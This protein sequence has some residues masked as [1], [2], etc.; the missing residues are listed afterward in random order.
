MTEVRRWMANWNMQE[1]YPN[2]DG[3]CV[4]FTDFDALRQQ[5]AVVT[6]HRDLFAKAI[7]DAAVKSGIARPDAELCGPMLLMLVDDMADCIIANSPKPEVEAIA[8]SD[9]SAKKDA[10]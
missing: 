9:H 1:H 8:I 7:G 5:L 2:K 4:L 6:H 3:E 10:P